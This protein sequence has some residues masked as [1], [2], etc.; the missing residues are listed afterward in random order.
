MQSAKRKSFISHFLRK[1][2]KLSLGSRG[3]VDMSGGGSGGASPESFIGAGLSV[4]VTNRG[5]PSAGDMGQA[6]AVTSNPKTMVGT[7]VLRQPRRCRREENNR[8]ARI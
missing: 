3:S 8:G 6:N 1:A 2:C 5:E 4:R 7:I